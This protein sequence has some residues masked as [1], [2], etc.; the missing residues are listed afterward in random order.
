MV[1][2][3]HELET[4]QERLNGVVFDVEYSV[5]GVKALG[6]SDAHVDVSCC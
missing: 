6:T 3:R 5:E 1:Q 4:L 2:R